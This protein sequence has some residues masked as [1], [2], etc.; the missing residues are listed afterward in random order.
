MSLSSTRQYLIS[1]KDKMDLAALV[2]WDE[3]ITSGIVFGSVLVVLL[4]L[5]SYSLITVWSYSCLTLLMV[6]HGMK[7]YNR[8]MVRIQEV[9]PNSE[10]LGNLLAAM[11]VKNISD[12]SPY[13]GNFVDKITTE[14]HRISTLETIM[15]GLSL[16]ILTYIGSL[17]NM[18]TMLTLGWVA[19]FSVPKVYV[20]VSGVMDPVVTKVMQGA[21]LVGVLGLSL[22]LLGML[23]TVLLIFLPI[24]FFERF[25][26]INYA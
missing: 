18:L 15:F 19:L 7:L 6:M 13:I 4:S 16:W 17:S 9:E 12:V 10:P 24:W 20:L 23:P 22:N 25:S 3:P 21:M 26:K 8:V 5:A 1:D 11:L 2:Y 14:L